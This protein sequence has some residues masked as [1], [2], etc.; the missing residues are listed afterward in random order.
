[1]AKTILSTKQRQIVAMESRLVI[2]RGE[3]GGA[4]MNKGV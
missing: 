1:M 2:T 4:R 3:G